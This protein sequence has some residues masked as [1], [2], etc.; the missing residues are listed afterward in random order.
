MGDESNKPSADVMVRSLGW[1]IA[2]A[3]IFLIVFCDG[4]VPT[5]TEMLEPVQP[6][7]FLAIVFLATLFATCFWFIKRGRGASGA[8]PSNLILVSS[9][10]TAVLFLLEFL[11][12]HVDVDAF[13]IDLVIMALSGIFCGTLLLFWTCRMTI[14]E[15]GSIVSRCCISFLVFG[16][17]V[18]TVAFISSD[19]RYFVLTF[20]SLASAAFSFTASDSVEDE[21]LVALRRPEDKLH[22]SVKSS[23]SYGGT[24]YAIGYCLFIYYGYSGMQAA[25]LV[26]SVS[27]IAAVAIVVVISRTIHGKGLL[28][29]PI[30]HW[31][32]PFTAFFFM[33]VHF[34]PEHLAQICVIVGITLLFLRYVSRA[35]DHV[36]IAQ[37][38]KMSNGKICAMTIM[39]LVSGMLVGICVAIVI[40]ASQS[41]AYSYFGLALM[42]LILIIASTLSPYGSD[43]L[44]MPKKANDSASSDQGSSG[45]EKGRYADAWIDACDRIVSEAS[46]T[47]REAEVFRLL[48]RGRSAAIIARSLDISAHTAQSHAYNI[49]RKVEVDGQQDLI[50]MVEN[51]FNE[52]ISDSADTKSR[53]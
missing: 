32:L 36:L 28:P 50:D 8:S 9:L 11:L 13:A 44:T 34:V 42:V 14:C 40:L 45:D 26:I 7:T 19:Y 41:M 39:P 17:C 18:L 35:I 25:A 12:Q 49:Y 48:A 51:G 22:L 43:P 20:I 52:A 27:A 10:A 38:Y 2:C 15:R 21:E 3:I 23:A 6:R 29:G 30:D 24:A 4:L 53:I 47:N 33:L 31:T 5:E 1:G 46:L 16:A 37:E